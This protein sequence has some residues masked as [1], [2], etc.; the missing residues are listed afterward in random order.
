MEFL[1]KL[2]SYEGHSVSG[3]DLRLAGHDAKNVLGADAVVYSLA[4]GKNNPEFA[5]A[6]RLN[7]PLFSRSE[8]LGKVARSYESVLAVSGTHGKTTTTAML[9]CAL[10][11]MNPTVHFGGYVNGV[12]GRIGGKNLFVTEA[13][14]YKE[15]FL[16]LDPDASIVLNVELDHADFFKTYESFYDA[17]DKLCHKSKTA[18]VCGDNEARTLKGAERTFTFGVKA[19]N[20]Y[21][22]EIEGEKNG[23]FTFIAHSPKGIMGSVS[24]NVRGEHNV[25]SAMAAIAYCDLI[26]SD[27]RG[28]ERFYGVDRRFET[29]YKGE[30]TEFITDYAHHP[31]E[32]D[33][34][35]AAARKVFGRVLTVFEPHTFTRTQA[36]EEM[37][38]ESLRRFDECILLPI[39]AAREL[40]IE[41]V[42]SEALAK[43]GGFLY[44]KDYDEAGEMLD[45]LSSGFDA[46]IFMGAGSI[47]DFAREYTLRLK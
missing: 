12:S 22:A 16:S 10:E 42:T 39:Y 3:S 5:E 37:F 41:G 7:I 6:Q 24:L 1:A 2:A 43:K 9:M 13:C 46:V 29:L 8:Y 44:A 4:V 45:R 21:Y 32:I 34:T 33:C 26:G 18:I 17:F 47:D 27:F 40:P 19:G 25:S 23:F 28:V 14:E 15:C 11:K 31:H 35:L 36:F 38:I 20:D 30:K